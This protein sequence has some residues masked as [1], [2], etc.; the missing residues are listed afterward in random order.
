[1]PIEQK[2]FSGVSHLEFTTKQIVEGALTG[3]HKSPFHG[4]SVE[5]LEHRLF[6]NGDETKNIDWKVF[7][8]T[9]KHFIKKFEEETNLNVQ[10]VLDTSSSMYFPDTKPPFEPGDNKMAFASYLAGCIMHICRKQRDAVALHL[11]DESIQVSTQAKTNHN[12]IHQLFD[13]LSKNLDEKKENTATGLSNVLNSILNRI[14]QR[15]I[16]IIL[17]DFLP[18][19]NDEATQNLMVAIQALKAK[20]SEVLFFQIA[21][22]ENESN[23]NYPNRPIKVVDQESGK[24]IKLHPNEVREAYAKAYKSNFSILKTQLLRQKVEFQRF[25]TSTPFLQALAPYLKRRSKMKI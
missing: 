13:V 19:T 16:V 12:H 18:I 25:T 10:I 7:A 24:T 11:F 3:I 2:H 22:E 14:N 23:F 4:F 15:S 9:G 17:S 21:D 8:K 5:F 6:Q 20:H 1:M